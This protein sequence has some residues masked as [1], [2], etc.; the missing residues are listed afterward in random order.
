MNKWIV[1]QLHKYLYLYLF[2]S[3]CVCVC[4]CVCSLAYRFTESMLVQMNR[5]RKYLT[6]SLLTEATIYFCF[7]RD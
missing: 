2:V 5:G 7:N 3:V 4:V 1:G 6:F